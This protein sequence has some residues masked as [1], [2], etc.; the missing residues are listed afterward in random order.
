MISSQ[1]SEIRL[2][3]LPIYLV[4]YIGVN[5]IDTVRSGC[6]C[7]GTDGGGGGPQR[8]KVRGEGKVTHQRLQS[9]NLKGIQLKEVWGIK[10]MNKRVEGH[11]S[12][13]MNLCR[14]ILPQDIGHIRILGV[15][16]KAKIINMFDSGRLVI[17]RRILKKGDLEKGR[18]IGRFFFF[19]RIIIFYNI[20]WTVI[21]Y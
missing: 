13:F 5:A 6:V 19:L 20:K 12:M 10:D 4:T 2:T 8:W 17:W 16:L 11:A 1:W 9:E 21:H 18:Y 15:Y 14:I 7:A 3:V